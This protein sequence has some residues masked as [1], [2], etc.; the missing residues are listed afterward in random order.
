MAKE[1]LDWPEEAKNVLL[2]TTNTYWDFENDTFQT[3]YST[4]LILDKESEKKTI[5]RTTEKPLG[6]QLHLT[7]LFIGFLKQVRKK[8]IFLHRKHNTTTV[9]KY[10]SP[11]PE[12]LKIG[13]SD[14]EELHSMTVNKKVLSKPIVEH[15]RLNPQ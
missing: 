12:T 7:F 8:Q 1:Y 3:S 5:K 6:N 4:E 15:K 10:H 2:A 13:K 14:S 9:I 11:H